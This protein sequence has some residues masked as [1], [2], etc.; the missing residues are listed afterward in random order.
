MNKSNWIQTACL[1]MLLP[2]LCASAANVPELIEFNGT[3]S[4]SETNAPV[5]GVHPF[6]VRLY[7]QLTD[8][9]LLW[10]E[11]ANVEVDAAG[12]YG[13]QL[14][15]GTR[16]ATTNTLSEALE[17][18]GSA[19]FLELEVIMN[20]QKRLFA[21]RRQLAST[22]FALMAGNTHQATQG[23][24]VGGMLIVEG[25]SQA[26]QVTAGTINAKEVVVTRQVSLLQGPLCADTMTSLSTNEPLVF[27]TG[28][29]SAKELQ[30][31]DSLAIFSMK[32]PQLTLV[33]PA[34]NCM[35]VAH[36]DCWLYMVVNA[37]FD[38]ETKVTVGTNVYTIPAL[39]YAIYPVP[40]PKGTPVQVSI[41]ETPI[42]MNTDVNN[43]EVFGGDIMNHT[44]F[45]SL[46]VSP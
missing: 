22:P 3:L 24:D 33:P 16:G 14:G 8:G 20:G 29:T 17:L 46:G 1:W 26:D 32:K 39:A 18:A 10:E 43:D 45:L 25:D 2:V 7:N 38:F 12:R 35:Y 34:S 21:P 15:A 9:T 41:F 40:V 44:F 13:V 27:S 5:A 42:A 37:G 6:T 31:D 19:A 11:Q 36:T 4:W 23:L 28:V 30:I